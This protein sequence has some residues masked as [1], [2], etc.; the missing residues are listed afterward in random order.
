LWTYNCVGKTKIEEIGLRVWEKI[1]SLNQLNHDIYGLALITQY[2]KREI[3]L[4]SKRNLSHV[5]NIQRKNKEIDEEIVNKKKEKQ[6]II[7]IMDFELKYKLGILRVLL[8][9]QSTKIFF[10][11]YSKTVS[12]V[13]ETILEK[14]GIEKNKVLSC[15]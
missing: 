7:E 15:Y 6:R 3:W 9:D 13:R 10:I 4:N 2:K 5:L 12:E 8:F 14:C 1:D 11:D